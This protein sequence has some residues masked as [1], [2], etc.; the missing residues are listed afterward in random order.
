MLLIISMVRANDS[1]GCYALNSDQSS[2][3][4]VINRGTA[5]DFDRLEKS[6]IVLQRGFKIR[7]AIAARE[8]SVAKLRARMIQ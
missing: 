1:W 8:A 6:V 5:S 2:P 3:M 4:G 7:V